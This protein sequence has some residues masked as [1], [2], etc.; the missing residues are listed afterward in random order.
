M[1]NLTQ[2]T[3]FR[4]FGCSTND[5]TEKF[6]SEPAKPEIHSVLKPF[7]TLVEENHDVSDVVHHR[8]LRPSLQEFFHQGIT[9][10]LQLG[11]L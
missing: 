5:N 11:G 2:S 8:L 9:P 6:L 1:E 10:F 4:V 7:L 3:L